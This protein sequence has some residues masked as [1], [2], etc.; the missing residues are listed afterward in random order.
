MGNDRRADDERLTKIIETIDDVRLMA[1]D[2][3]NNIKEMTEKF[4]SV[5]TIFEKVSGFIWVIQGVTKFV[6]FLGGLAGAA[7]GIIRISEKL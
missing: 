4:D 2:N 7:W 5:Y 3:R 6:L 1:I